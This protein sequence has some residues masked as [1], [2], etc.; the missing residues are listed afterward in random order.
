MR[1]YA[2]ELSRHL[3]LPLL[4]LDESFTTQ[5]AAQSMR[6]RGITAKEQRGRVDAVAAAILLQDYLDSKIK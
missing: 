6:A 5:R 4:L 2:W 3:G 1:D